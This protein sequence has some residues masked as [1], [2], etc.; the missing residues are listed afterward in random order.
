MK[1]ILAI[2]VFGAILAAGLFLSENISRFDAE[3]PTR[4]TPALEPLPERLSRVTVPISVPITAVKEALERRTPKQKSGFKKDGLGGRFAQSELGWDLRRSDLR[5]SG[6][7]GTLS[8]A[9]ELR[10]EARAEGTLQLIRKVGFSARGDILASASLTAHPAL[11]EN[12]RISPNLSEAKI[13]IK[14][15]NIP[16]KRVGSL[17]VRSHLLP[18]LEIAVDNLRGQLNSH[19]ARNNF[20][21]RAARKSWKRLCASTPLKEDS[22]LWIE[23]KP[24][25]AH[26]TQI[27]I[28]R[29]NIRF[30]LGVD[31]K[32]HILP[33]ETQPECPF[34]EKLLIEKPKR[35]GF[36]I[37]MPARIDYETLEKTLADEVVG[38]SFGKNVSITIKAIRMRPYGEMLLLET[39]VGAEADYLSGAGTKGTLYVLAEPKLNA[40]AQT[41]TLENVRL[42]TDSQNVLFSIAGKAAEPLLLEAVSKRLPFNLGPK[43]EELRNGAQDAI[44]ALSSEN[45]SVSG[46]VNR[47]RIT[48]LDVGPEHLRLVLT[49]RGRVSAAVGAI[50]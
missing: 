5:V 20:L 30:T 6:Q 29:E 36:E 17:D 23:T 44:L 21:E 13:D 38:K 25:A 45:V 26:A 19:L 49:A 27:R 43:L 41:V 8:V 14:R 46:K 15:A 28:G 31:V 10:G 1:R 42:E 24:I 2:L 32:T 37:V 22:G 50:P 4:K 9:T 7:S 47:V 35:R 40:A 18:G 16:I 11:K 12:W 3:R 34:P 33:E 39:T 48:R